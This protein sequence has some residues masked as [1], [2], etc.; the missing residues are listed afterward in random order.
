MRQEQFGD[1]TEKLF[2][3]FLFYF[4]LFWEFTVTM[5]IDIFMCW[6]N[7]KTKAIFERSFQK[8][9]V[10]IGGLGRLE[11]MIVLLGM[12]GRGLRIE[13]VVSWNV[14]R[15][16]SFRMRTRERWNCLGNTTFRAA[17]L[18]H[19]IGLCLLWLNLC[20]IIQPGRQ[21]MILK[22]GRCEIIFIN[23]AS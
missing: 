7:F 4:F 21:Q 19:R 2:W 17:T 23:C 18:P 10:I 12:L 14:S 11:A 16:L 3:E 6:K 20:A 1:K 22:K 5:L 13:Q 9:Q 15:S 8:N